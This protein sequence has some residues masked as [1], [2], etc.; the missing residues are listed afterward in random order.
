MEME[1][2]GRHPEEKSQ[3]KILFPHHKNIHWRQCKTNSHTQQTNKNQ[4]K[5]LMKK[6]QKK[7]EINLKSYFSCNYVNL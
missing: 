4:L 5:N 6:N 1:F 2:K 3:H 7:E